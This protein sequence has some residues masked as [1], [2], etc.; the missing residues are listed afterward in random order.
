MT[1]S[2]ESDE[3][4]VEYEDDANEQD[5]VDLTAMDPDEIDVE[6]LD[7]QEW[8]L[9]GETQEFIKFGG[10]V[11]LVEDPDDD[12]ILNLIASS[13]MAAEGD[14]SGL[15]DGSDR[16]YQFVETAIVKP[17]MTPEKW[18]TL[19]SGERVGLTM[20]VAEFAGLSQLMD[21]QDGGPTPQPEG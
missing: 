13:A 20:R 4:D 11:F 3:N 8:T 12:T 10:M 15:E 16:M 5:P 9:G 17:E 19:K 7:D 18:R 1:D 21:F 14:D 6:D 2:P